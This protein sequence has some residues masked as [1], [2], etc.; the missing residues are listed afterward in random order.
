[1]RAVWYIVDA[2]YEAD[3]RRGRG[4]YAKKGDGSKS[5]IDA[6]FW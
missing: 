1:M 2:D 5:S 6:L 3:D 4:S